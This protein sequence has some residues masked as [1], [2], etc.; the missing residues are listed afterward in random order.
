M[1]HRIWN[2]FLSRHRRW[3]GDPGGNL[4]M[5]DD[6]LCNRHVEYHMEKVDGWLR[7]WYVYVPEAVR[8]HPEVPVPLVFAC[9]GYT[10]NGAFTWKTPAGTV[11]LMKTA[12]W[13]FTRPQAMVR[14]V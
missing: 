12:L 6:P 4:R 14:C 13:L 3:M 9:H 8:Q 11:S 7:E 1:L 5:Y 2:G 10:C